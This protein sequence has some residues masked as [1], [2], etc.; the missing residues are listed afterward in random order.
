MMQRYH[1]IQQ[2]GHTLYHCTDDLKHVQSDCE[3]STAKESTT[4]SSGHAWAEITSQLHQYQCFHI[5]CLGTENS[6]GD[7]QTKED[8]PSWQILFTQK[9]H[10]LKFYV[11]SR[12]VQTMPS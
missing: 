7:S 1:N 10:Q 9:A 8:S 6:R 5:T 11:V 12:T 2:V 4:L 3:F